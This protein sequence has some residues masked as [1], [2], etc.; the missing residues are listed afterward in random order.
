[1]PFIQRVVQPVNLAQACSITSASGG[2]RTRFLCMPGKC[3]NQNCINNKPAQRRDSSLPK[4]LNIY[5]NNNNNSKNTNNNVKDKDNTSILKSPTASTATT[6]STNSSSSTTTVTTA[7]IHNSSAKE[8]ANKDT[9]TE[10]HQQLLNGF[11]N[12]F[13]YQTDHEDDGSSSNIITPVSPAPVMS[14]KKLK[15]HVEFLPTV[16]S[17]TR[18]QHHAL[19][20]ARPTHLSSGSHSAPNSGA[21]TAANSRSSSHSRLRSPAAQTPQSPIGTK[22]IAGYEFDSISNITLSNALRQL[23]S[24]VLIA[25]DIFDDLQRELQTVGERARGVQ[26]K[27]MAV[28]QRV[29]AYDPKMVTVRKYIKIT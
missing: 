27:I 22:I 11:T 16:P 6:T 18:S 19:S 5:H 4:E 8:T 15:Q 12:S 9:T 17:P 24:L 26:K 28:E 3:Q 13:A 20:T 14:M 29:S 1:M 21:G 23:A 7:I 10:H 25:S 2:T